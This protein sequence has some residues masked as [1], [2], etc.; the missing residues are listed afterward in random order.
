VFWLVAVVWKRFAKLCLRL[1][2]PKAAAMA[3]GIAALVYAAMAGFAIPTQRALIMLAVIIVTLLLGRPVRGTTTLSLALL[4]VLLFDP[5]A[6]LAPGFWLSFFAVAVIFWMTGFRSQLP[7]WQQW[8]LL[9]AVLSLTLL[10]VTIWFFQ[11]ASLIAPLTNF[12]A[13]PLVGFLIV[14]LALS[15]ALLLPLFPAIGTGLLMLVAYLLEGLMKLLKLAAGLPLSQL[16]LPQPAPIILL[17]AVAGVGILLLPRGLPG[18][19]LGALLLLP[20]LLNSPV[21]P[22]TGAFRVTVLDVGQ[23]LSIVVQT[24]EHSLLFDAG[25]RFSSNFNAGDAVVLPFL[26][27]EGVSHLDRFVVSHADNDHRG[28]MEAVLAAVSVDQLLTSD[29]SLATE[30]DGQLCQAGQRWIWDNVEFSVLHPQ[31]DLQASKNDAACVIRI[32]NDSGSF[33]LTADIEKKAEQIL[34]QQIP[35]TLVSTVMLVPHHGSKTSST[36]AFVQAVAPRLAL[37]S[38]G[39]LN[40]F[41]F[42]RPE[43]VERYRKQGIELLDTATSGALIVDFP[44]TGDFRLEAYRWHHSHFWHA[45]PVKQRAQDSA[46]VMNPL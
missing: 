28:G 8:G 34:L 16:S 37:L 10:P 25:A 44:R 12:L 35:E 23:G 26:R 40:S 1:P 7:K 36:L 9:Q 24:A 46:A 17:L 33:L 22:E 18:R 41:G 19:Y 11:R 14:P 5:F 3:A 6:V 43:I 39:Y 31:P 4:L 21:R 38:V 20:L 45:S 13:V 30:H 2:A 15:G 27:H 29:Q 32:A 42:P